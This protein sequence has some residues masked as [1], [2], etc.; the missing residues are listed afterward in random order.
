MICNKLFA[1]IGIAAIVIGSCV[2]AETFIGRTMSDNVN[3]D[4]Y[5]EL[6]HPIYNIGDTETI[7]YKDELNIIFESVKEMNIDDI[8]VTNDNFIGIITSIDDGKYVAVPYELSKLIENGRITVSRNN[9]TKDNIDIPWCFGYNTDKSKQCRAPVDDI[10]MFHNDILDV[11][12]DNCF[13]GLSGDVFADIEFHKF[14]I[15]KL[16]VGLKKMYIKG[17]I[18]MDI[19]SK[20]VWSYSY[21]HIYKVLD[22]FKI[23]SFKIGVINFDIFVDFVVH[24]DFNA[25]ADYHSNIN[26][27]VNMDVD[28][29]DVY[30]NFENGKWNIVE[31]HPNVCVIPYVSAETT[32]NGRAHFDVVPEM[33]VYT[34][35]VFSVHLKFDPNSDLSTHGSATEKQICIDGK[36]DMSLT[37][38]ATV[39]KETIPDKTVYNSGTQKIIDKCKK[40]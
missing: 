28:I 17:G 5:V 14:K 24:L 38:G 21:N 7:L 16:Q 37:I 23:V 10:N 8:I 25:F 4:Y 15:T 31:P 34:P 18:G 12:C 36:Y 27:G 2:S 30:V 33:S 22:K 29:G 40:F 35:S 11:N 13:V 32:I 6:E 19:D 20:Y 1:L 9:A 39:L 3:I 26:Y